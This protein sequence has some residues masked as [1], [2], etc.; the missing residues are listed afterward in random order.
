MERYWFSSLGHCFDLS[1]QDIAS[2]AAAVIRTDWEYPGRLHWEEDERARRRIFNPEDAYQSHGQY[3]R[4]DGLTFYLSFH[5][6]MVA[7]GK[8]LAT[9][10]VCCYPDSA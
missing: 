5:A 4:A 7:A 3:P 9:T 1:E 6:M 2:Q 10:P 8:L